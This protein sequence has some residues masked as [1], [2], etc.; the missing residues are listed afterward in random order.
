MAAPRGLKEGPFLIG[1]GYQKQVG[2]D[3]VAGELETALETL[4]FSTMIYSIAAPL[5]NLIH[6][7]YGVPMGRL[8]GDDEAKNKPS[9]VRGMTV[10]Q[11]LQVFGCE[12]REAF[13]GIWSGAL[14][15]REWHNPWYYSPFM[16]AVIIPD[17]RFRD[18]FDIIKRRGIT[19]K[20]TRPGAP[21]DPH[22]SEKSSPVANAPWDLTIE[23]G[24]TLD[25]LRSL[26]GEIA[27]D[28]LAPAIA[29]RNAYREE[30]GDL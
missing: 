9:G 30:H 16:E 2:K 22:W 21:T 27:R 1:L 4:E 20:V 7:V 24:G 15:R 10:R 17:V 8:Y 29:E 12:M 3:T 18:E 6:E 13:P 25:E 11:L 14:L 19:I 5:K 26:V 23:N 28:R